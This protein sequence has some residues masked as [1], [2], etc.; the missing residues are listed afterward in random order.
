MGTADGTVT[1][2]TKV[3]DHGPDADR[4]VIAVMG[5]GFTAAQQSAYQTAFTN[6]TNALKATKPFDAVWNQINVH[7]VD[8]QSNQSGADNPQTC[9]TSPPPVGGAMTANTYLDARYCGDGTIR[10]LLIVDSALAQTTANARVP[11][12]DVIVVVVNHVEYGG[13]GASK[14]AAYSLAADALQVAL[15]ELGHSAYKLADEYEYFRGCTS[16]E[17]DRNT[18]TGSEPSEPNVTT[19]TDRA[20]LKW[21][22]LVD[23]ATPVPTTTNTDCTK[24]DPQANPV[25]ADAI[26]A[27]AGA[28]Y[29]HCGLYRPAYDCL[30]RTVGPSQRFCKVCQEAIKAEIIKGSKPAC[31]VASA[32]YADTTHPDVLWL[33]GW[34]DRRLAPG[35]RGRIG[36]RALV[37][38]YARVGPSAARYVQRHP[39]VARL[40]RD[41]VL[42]PIVTAARRHGRRG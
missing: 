3:I 31:F 37:A 25:G 24:C 16:G 27:F 34:R 20:K 19:V 2:S 7:R 10:R 30:M 8:I 9:G 11:N 1:G 26:G 4:Y 13:S 36:M 21:R 15:H 23:A 39:T 14:V 40:L 29:F 35:A 17:T 18:Y 38:T 32:V 12:W 41:H 33:R 22:H 42:G 5:D 28:Q 6:F